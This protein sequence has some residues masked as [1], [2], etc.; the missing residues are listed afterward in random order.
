MYKKLENNS[1]LET[2]ISFV[3]LEHKH[4]LTCNTRHEPI[5]GCYAS[6]S[7]LSINNNY[8]H[9]VAFFQ[10]RLSIT[11]LGLKITDTIGNRLTKYI[12]LDTANKITLGRSDGWDTK[13][14]LPYVTENE[15]QN[16]KKHYA[17]WLFVDILNTKIYRY[18]IMNTGN[19]VPI[20]S[21]TK[22]GFAIMFDGKLYRYT[23]RGD[24]I[25]QHVSQYHGPTLTSFLYDNSSVGL[26]IYKEKNKSH[27]LHF[28]NAGLP[29]VHST[30][31]KSD[32]IYRVERSS[33]YQPI[34][35][36]FYKNTV[37]VYTYITTPYISYQF[38]LDLPET[39]TEMSVNVDSLGRFSILSSTATITTKHIYA[40]TGEL[41]KKKSYKES[42]VLE[43]GTARHQNTTPG[44]QATNFVF[45]SK[46]TYHCGDPH[47]IITNMIASNIAHWITPLQF[48]KMHLVSINDTVCLGANSSYLSNNLCTSSERTVLYALA[49]FLSFPLEKDIN[50]QIRCHTDNENTGSIPY[51]PFSYKLVDNDLQI[52]KSLTRT[53]DKYNWLISKPSLDC[54]DLSSCDVNLL[55]SIYTNILTLDQ[56]MMFNLIDSTICS[57]TEIFD[58]SRL[59]SLSTFIKLDLTEKIETIKELMGTSDGMTIDN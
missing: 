45:S 39:I 28:D 21:V 16:I 33:T 14:V 38:H 29:L 10:K 49:S 26:G 2:V 3:K 20:G 1:L 51:H 24:E 15:H 34:I 31:L 37:Y 22:D 54:A 8:L 43:H 42:L 30:E 58:E 7:F 23:L 40:S 18:S 41:L 53:Y 57:V 17:K 44:V 27:S 52:I 48:E 11:E 6:C 36:G 4:N 59:E 19:I 9:F 32:T 47:T 46:Y 13:V 25:I 55:R 56:E 5:L 50:N 35:Y 12:V